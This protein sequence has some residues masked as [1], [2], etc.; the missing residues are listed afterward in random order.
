MTPAT[1]RR[2]GD[3]EAAI[4][5]AVFEQLEAVGYRKLT[6]EGIAATART[7]KAALYRRWQ[8]KDELITDALKHVLPEPPALPTTGAI[9]ADLLAALTCLRDTLTA[10][11]GAAFKVLKE[12]GSP[13]DGGGLLHDVIRQRVSLPVREFTYRSLVLAAERGEI[14]PEAA[15][16]QIAAVGTAVIIYHNLTEGGVITDAYLESVVDDVLMPLVRRC[17]GT[18]SEG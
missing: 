4:Y 18:R 8:S 5:D 6:M 15:T 3:L 7:G 11:R 10:C 16:R 13:D 1:R 12:A 14:R 17:D 2:G 9:R